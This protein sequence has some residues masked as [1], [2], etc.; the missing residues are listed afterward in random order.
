MTLPKTADV[1]IIGGGI[2]GVSIAYYLAQRNVGRIV[3]LERA[4]L[5]S[6]STGRSVASIDL[7]SSQPAAIQLQAHAYHIF[8][9]FDELVGDTCGLVTSGFA[10][11]GGPENVVDLQRAIAITKAAGID[12]Q[13]L[14]PAEFSALEPTANIEDL[15]AICY[16]AA[17]G[18]G[19]PALTLNAYTVAAR[20]AGVVIQ[21]GQPV[22]DLIQQGGRVTGIGTASATIAT[23]TVVCAAGPWS[24]HLLRTFGLNDLGLH[25]VRH[26]VI[27]MKGA[28]ER[29][30]P[31][32]SILDLPNSIYA[33]PES[34][35]LTLAGSITPDIG[36]APTEP[37]DGERRAVADDVYWCA[38]QLVERYPTLETAELRPGWTGLLSISPDWQPM[39]GVL[40]Q[41]F[42]LYCAT[43]CSGQGFKIS[44]AVGDLMAGLLAGEADAAELLAPFQPARFA[45]NKPL[46]AG[47]LAF[48]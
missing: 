18:Y 28:D 36:Y 3:V 2:I 33:R 39:L 13:W 41:V 17:A 22:T 45:E 43:G 48:L 6:G 1:V 4:T 23:P 37:E 31:R 11:L 44:P 24:S 42:G 9:H 30:T 14:S 40:P 27:V 19:D 20:R 8:S 25:A 16:V 32:L 47:E 21:Q 12:A 35:G 26:P 34:G 38:E 5:G 7:F 29:Y 15:A 10:V 46:T